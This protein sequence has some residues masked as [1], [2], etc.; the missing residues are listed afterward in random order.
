VTTLPARSFRVRLKSA[1]RDLSNVSKSA[2]E[3]SVDVPFGLTTA[4]L[5]G[6]WHTQQGFEL[7]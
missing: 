7:S 2:G 3:V 4:M 6:F 5:E 1:E